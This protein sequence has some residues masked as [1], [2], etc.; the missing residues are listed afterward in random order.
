[1]RAYGYRT[2]DML[3]DRLCDATIPRCDARRRPSASPG[4]RPRRARTSTRCSSAASAT[5]WSS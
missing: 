5:C 1:M 2:V 4:R 3:V